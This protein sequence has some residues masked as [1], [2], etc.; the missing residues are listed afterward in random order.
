MFLN[1]DGHGGIFK[2][3][4]Q[5]GVLDILK[6]KNIEFI[7]YHQVDNPLI[8]TID[9]EFLGT[10]VASNAQMSTKVVEKSYPEEKVGLVVE[11]DKKP[12]IIEYSELSDDLAKQRDDDGR[13]SLRAGNI[14]MHIINIETLE[15]FANNP[16]PFHTAFKKIPFVDDTG[17]IVQPSTPNGYKFEQLVFDVLPQVNKTVTF[18]VGREDEFAPIKNASGKDSPEE[19]TR[20][21]SD[22]Y[23]QWMIDAGLEKKQVKQMKSVEVSPLF[24]LNKE[25]FINKIR[26][27]KECWESDLRDKTE[28]V[29]DASR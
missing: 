14:A 7:M 10:H 12:R 19:S 6:K 13:L 25:D 8:S 28:Y 18:M 21:Q 15:E 17:A 22:L 2:A 27:A 3:F 9:P 1:P 29:F 24:A 16:L 11:Y 26:L 23:K 5:T 4:K 20:I